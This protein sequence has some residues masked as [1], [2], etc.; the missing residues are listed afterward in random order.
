MNARRGRAVSGAFVFLLLGIFALF[1]VMLVM[2]GAR[3]YHST[4]ESGA[5]HGDGRVLE[6]Y[7]VNAVRADDALGAVSVQEINGMDVLKISADYAGTGYDKWIYC[8]NGSLRELFVDS[9]FEFD[10]DSGEIICPAQDMKL[11]LHGA[12]LSA[13]LTDSSGAEHQAMVAL[14]CAG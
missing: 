11:D 14:H 13:M 9:E 7:L 2:L 5:V 6:S 10:P 4:V 1:A 12:L 8:W 3:A